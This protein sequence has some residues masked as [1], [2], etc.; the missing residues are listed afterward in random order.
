MIKMKNLVISTGAGISAES[1][2]STFRDSGGLWEQ[3][4]VMDVASDEGFARNPAL[5]H[6]FYNDRRRQLL[7]AKPNAAHYGLVELEKHF[8][9][10]VVTQNVDDLHERAGSKNVLHLH[11]ELMKV[12]SMTHPERVYT[13]P[14][15][16][17]SDKGLDTSPD[18][19]DAFG[20]HV[21]PHIVFFG[22]AVPNFDPACRLAAKADIFVVIGTT[23]AVYP[24]AALLQY[25]PPSA[26]I[27]YID[28]NPAAVPSHVHVIAKKATEGVADLISILTNKRH[29][30]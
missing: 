19:V 10:N 11:G 14:C 23:L 12:R 8:N 29:T 3:H 13:L 21:R 24:A 7:E 1:G 4:N 25:A 5:V 27:Y 28:P 6:Q 22:E 15:S 30:L 17:L 16:E 20:D 2:I 18:T 9:V 26:E